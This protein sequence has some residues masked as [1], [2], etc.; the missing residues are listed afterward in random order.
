VSGHAIVA[1]ARACLGVRFRPQGRNP[2]CGLDC[3]G[4]VLVALGP[5]MGGH[6]VA[7]DYALSGSGLAAQAEAGLAD[8]GGMQ[9]A[10]GVPGDIVLFEPAKGQGHLA[11]LSE[12]GVIHA[13]LGL[14]RVVEAPFDRTWGVRSI[15]QF[16]GA[17]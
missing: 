7:R 5:V 2:A 8:A 13:H 12:Q 16:E 17:D 6:A 1:R 11:V 9:V 14:R 3:V 4:L 10:A 15:W